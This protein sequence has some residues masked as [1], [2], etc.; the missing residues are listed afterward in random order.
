MKILIADDDP[1]TLDSLEACLKGE[2]F[3]VLPARDG[4]QALELW[5]SGGR[6]C[7]ASTS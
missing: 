7:S 1:V 4:R 6:T 5:E 2:G 3:E